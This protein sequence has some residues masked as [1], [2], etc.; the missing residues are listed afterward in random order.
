MKL[1]VLAIIA[2]GHVLIEGIPGIAKTLT[3][4]TVAKLLNLKFSRIQ[5]TPDLLPAD[6]V[7]TKVYNQ[8]TGDFEVVVGPV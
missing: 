5:L 1:L 4:K 8:K 7:G 3:A 6:I 2:G